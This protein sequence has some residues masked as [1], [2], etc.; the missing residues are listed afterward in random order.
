MP[1]YFL[2]DGHVAGVEVLP[3]GLS[4]EGA[5]ARAHVLL[6]KRKGPLDGFEVWDRARFVPHGRALSSRRMTSL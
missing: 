3:L 5:I 6:S 2:R 4:D 1:C